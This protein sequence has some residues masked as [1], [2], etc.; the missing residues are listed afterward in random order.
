MH[1][2]HYLIDDVASTVIQFWA[3]TVTKLHC[4][5]ILCEP[6]VGIRIELY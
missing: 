5:I 3:Y 2:E 6:Y 1:S 4:V